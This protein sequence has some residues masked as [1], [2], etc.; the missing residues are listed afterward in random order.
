LYI[1]QN[2]I[3]M[4]KTLIYF[5]LIIGLFA[6]AGEPTTAEDSVDNSEGA[7]TEDQNSGFT[8]GPQSVVP[9][10]NIFGED[11]TD[12]EGNVVYP[13]RDTIWN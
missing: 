1:S 13:P 8:L 2:L 7:T 12:V 6:C 3:V 5:S 11:S 9:L 4:K 10:V